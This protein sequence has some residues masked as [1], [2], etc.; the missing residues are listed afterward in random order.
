MKCHTAASRSRGR[1]ASAAE[2]ASRKILLG[3]GGSH[4][5][6]VELQPVAIGVPKVEA[7]R[8]PVISSELDFRAPPLQQVVK[9]P[10]CSEPPSIR[11]AVWA[12]PELPT[13]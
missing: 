7:L 4:H 13:G 9:V 11:M 3:L 10:S 2:E 5:L 12:R 1:R 6:G 8:D